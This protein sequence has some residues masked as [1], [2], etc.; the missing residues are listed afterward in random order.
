LRTAKV[1]NSVYEWTQ[2]LP[3]AKA[4]GVSDDQIA[5]IES[6]EPARCYNELERLV[7]RF[8]DEIARG[9]KGKKET[10]AE[11]QKT[12]GTRTDRGANHVYR[13]LGNG[14]ARAGDHRS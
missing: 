6:W 9:V 4:V 11:L 3:I 1:S 7:L 13:L 2:H 12:S 10:L 14:R 8:T 5:A